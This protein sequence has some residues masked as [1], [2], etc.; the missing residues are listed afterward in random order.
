[1]YPTP[2]GKDMFWWCWYHVSRG[3]V[4]LILPGIDEGAGPSPLRRGQI[5]AG[6]LGP[7][8]GGGGAPNVAC[9]F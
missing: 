3:G 5:G 7:L 1:M 6:G 2:G 4:K 8:M 9:R